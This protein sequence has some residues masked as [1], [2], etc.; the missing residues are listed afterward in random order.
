MG[1]RKLADRG[2]TEAQYNLGSAYNLGVGVPKD[3]AEA[4][5]WYRKAADQGHVVGQLNPG[6]LY[7]DGGGAPRDYTMSIACFNIAATSGDNDSVDTR[8]EALKL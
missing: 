8:S 1:F 4:A 6:V 2:D 7:A 3:Y 5:K